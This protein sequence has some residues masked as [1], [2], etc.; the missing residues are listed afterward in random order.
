MR[1]FMDKLAKHLAPDTR[2]VL[3]TNAACRER[4]TV[5]FNSGRATCPRCGNQW[6]LKQAH[7]IRAERGRP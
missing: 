3:C 5:S 4:V 6:T 1:T 2:D 7:L